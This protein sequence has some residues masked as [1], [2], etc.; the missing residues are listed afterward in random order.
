ML[1]TVIITDA[2]QVGWGA[3]T[4]RVLSE[5]TDVLSSKT[6][7]ALIELISAISQI[8]VFNDKSLS[9][10]PMRWCGGSWSKQQQRRSSTYRARVAQLYA[11]EDS[12]TYCCGVTVL[13]SDNI[14]VSKCL[15]ELDAEY[16]GEFFLFF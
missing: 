1:G 12:L 15:R 9:L 14:N 3:L 8:D 7:P 16:N 2:N 10:H 4:L 11:T 5:G 13:V 6:D